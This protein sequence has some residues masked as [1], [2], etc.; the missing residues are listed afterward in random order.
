M[1]RGRRGAGGGRGEVAPY[2]PQGLWEEPLYA[3]AVATNHKAPV[4]A[5]QAEGEGLRLPLSNLIGQWPGARPHPYALELCAWLESRLSLRKE[6]R[7]GQGEEREGRKVAANHEAELIVLT[8]TKLTQTV[9]WTH[10]NSTIPTDNTGSQIA[11]ESV[12]IL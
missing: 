11:R 2:P 10:T 1:R 3:A 5:V 6:G 8:D 7:R 12:T 4:Q 9:T